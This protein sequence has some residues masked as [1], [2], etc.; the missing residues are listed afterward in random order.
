[1]PFFTS[2]G[3]GILGALGAT[4][5]SATLAGAT[6][7]AATAGIAAGGIAGANALANSNKPKEN[8]LGAMPAAP[9]PVDAAQ[10]AKEETDRLRRM[11]A[12]SGGKTI[13]TSEGM[14]SGTGKT[15]L[16]G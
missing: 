13:L 15:L 16:G 4:S 3:A 11:R 9:T 7:M 14:G 12:M 8:K 1:M 6:G 10:V 2:L 5:M